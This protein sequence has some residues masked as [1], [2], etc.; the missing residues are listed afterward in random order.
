MDNIILRGLQPLKIL[1]I[2][3]VVDVILEE[4]ID[5]LQYSTHHTFPPHFIDKMKTQLVHKSATYTLIG[6]V[7]YKRETN[8]VLRRYIFQSEVDLILECCHLDS[9]GG[10]FDGDS[11]ARKALLARYWW[12]TMFSNAYQFVYCCDAC[13]PIGCP[14]GTSA[15]LLVLIL[16]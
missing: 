1:N 3:F 16:A 11:T 5:L 10:H 6:G 7:L 2:R 15:M 12:L 9:C 4:Y 14:I 13:Q 8:E